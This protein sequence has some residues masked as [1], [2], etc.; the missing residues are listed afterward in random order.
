MYRVLKPFELFEPATVEEALHLLSMHRAKAK[1]MAGGVDLVMK[2][3]LRQVLPEYVVSI[4]EIPG[5]AY[6]R[7]DQ[8]TGLKIG[9]MATLRQVELSPLVGA[10]CPVLCEAINAIPKLQVKT[11]G[12]AVGNLCVATPATDI[13]P[14]LFVMG[15]NVK[16]ASNGGEKVVPIE[17]F[18]VAEGKTV[19][20]PEEMVTEILVP[21]PPLKMGCAFLR[22]GRTKADIPKVNVAVMVS[23]GANNRCLDFKVALGCVAPTVIRA[24]KSEKIL[25]GRRLTDEAIFMAAEV[26]AQESRPRS[27]V[28]YKREMV[29]VLVKDALEKA[30]A[31]A[32]V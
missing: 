17:D 22:I 4:S 12:T 14:A 1:V 29:K 19:L 13:A 24:V 32:Q 21:S 10:V 27:S 7:G 16:I 8:K 15:A 2:M 28:E 26:A 9:T 3:R 18:F 23:L 11:M 31:R 20:S 5:L 6:I 25:R 30:I